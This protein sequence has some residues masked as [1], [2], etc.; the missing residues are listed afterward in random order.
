MIKQTRFPPSTCPNLIF[1]PALRLLVW[2]RD[3][4]SPNP[5]D[6]LHSVDSEVNSFRRQKKTC[7][8]LV[9]KPIGEERRFG[10]E[11]SH[12]IAYCRKWSLGRLFLSLSSFS[13]IGSIG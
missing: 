3:H 1:P 5:F 9:E 7:V 6:S 13:S 4:H 12:R 11:W 8:A 2:S 10:Q